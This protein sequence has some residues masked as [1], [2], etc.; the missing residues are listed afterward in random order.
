MLHQEKVVALYRVTQNKKGWYRKFK[1]G[2]Q[3]SSLLRNISVR[4]S[5]YLH[6]PV[7]NTNGRNENDLLTVASLL[8]IVPFAPPVMVRAEK[9]Q[10]LMSQLNTLLL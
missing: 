7:I 4:A 8:T 9:S 3:V 1:A 2:Q 5:G 6:T 10:V